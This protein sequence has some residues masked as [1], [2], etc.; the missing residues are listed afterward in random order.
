MSSVGVTVSI[1]LAAHL[2]DWQAAQELADLALYRAKS[3]GRNR[4]IGLG[5]TEPASTASPPQQLA[6]ALDS[7]V[8]AGQLRLLRSPPGTTG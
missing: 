3:E 2:P 1:G 8:D 7:L 4:V 6:P 5:W